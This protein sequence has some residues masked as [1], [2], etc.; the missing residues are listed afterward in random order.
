[1]KCPKCDSEM[2]IDGNTNETEE[3]LNMI[4]YNCPECDTN[5]SINMEGRS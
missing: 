5:V 1:M 3:E 4:N 2:L